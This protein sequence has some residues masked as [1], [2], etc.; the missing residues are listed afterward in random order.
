K[1]FKAYFETESNSVISKDLDELKTAY[2]TNGRVVET[3]EF[4]KFMKDNQ[5]EFTFDDMICAEE[6]SEDE[7]KGHDHSHD[8]NH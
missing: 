4:K 2:E 8:H 7:H 1:L 3:K 5:I 6:D